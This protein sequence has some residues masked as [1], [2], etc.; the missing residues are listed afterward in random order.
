MQAWRRKRKH[1]N[2]AVNSHVK[3]TDDFLNL[4]KKK[5]QSLSIKSKCKINKVEC[6]LD[7]NQMHQ[8]KLLQRKYVGRL[9]P[10]HWDYHHHFSQS[11]YSWKTFVSFEQITRCQQSVGLLSGASIHINKRKPC[12]KPVVV[13]NML[14]ELDGGFHAV[15]LMLCFWK[16]RPP[17]LTALC[18]TV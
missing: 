15:C 13:I 17:T 5:P 9:D 16:D 10:G 14:L 11:F 2:C 12:N 6:L 7:H 18:F 4:K 8:G 1:I 3:Q